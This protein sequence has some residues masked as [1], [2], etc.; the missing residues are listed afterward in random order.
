MYLL[1][2]GGGSVVGEGV[3]ERVGVVKGNNPVLCVL[4][5]DKGGVGKC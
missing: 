2:G 5:L 1:G 3:G 4:E